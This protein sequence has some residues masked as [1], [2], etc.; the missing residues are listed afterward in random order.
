[1]HSIKKV[2]E[3]NPCHLICKKAD[4]TLAGFGV[5]ILEQESL[6]QM[7]DSKTISTT[8]IEW[9]FDVWAVIYAHI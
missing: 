5:Y 6:L 2:L 1:M 9:Q 4:M 8:K 7:M 3:Q